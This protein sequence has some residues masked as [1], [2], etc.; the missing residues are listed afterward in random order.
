MQKARAS[1]QQVKKNKKWVGWKKRRATTS[2]RVDLTQKASRK[3]VNILQEEKE[4][5]PET[6]SEGRGRIGKQ[7]R[8]ARSST[9]GARWPKN[10]K[11]KG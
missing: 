3:E 9:L 7:R 4:K 8:S 2:P 1:L 10:G 5:R 6:R 11:R